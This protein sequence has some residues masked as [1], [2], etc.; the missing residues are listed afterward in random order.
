L[1][2][3][4]LIDI[5]RRCEVTIGADP[6]AH[7]GEKVAAEQ[8]EAA[9]LERLLMAER[10]ETARAERRWQRTVLPFMVGALVLAAV[11]FGWTTYAFFDRLQSELSYGKTEPY[12]LIDRVDKV[13]QGAENLSYRDWAVR[14]TLEH[15][16]LE[17]RFNVQVAIVKG[18]LWSRFMGFLTGMLLALTGC[19]FVLGKLRSDIDFS[20]AASGASAIL[21]TT[22]PGVYLALLGTV[23]IG[24]A[25]AVPGEVE[26]T[27]AAVYFPAVKAS[28]S[29]ASAP[30]T[31]TTP[32]V[33]LPGSGASG[34][35]TVV[36]PY[37]SPFA[38]GAVPATTR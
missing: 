21:K 20:G 7:V 34:T 26:S 14:A 30:A 19:V 35:K 1:S 2:E 27:D 29:T 12:G 9:R 3:G 17:H 32:P 5:W 33:S 23:V 24:M 8:V 25:L 13:M 10:L 16:A 15:A 36:P 18:R 11:F 38:S 22:S 31:V 28:S 37:P 6:A 4:H